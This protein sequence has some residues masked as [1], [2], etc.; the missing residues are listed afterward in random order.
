MRRIS[1]LSG[2]SWGLIAI[3]PATAADLPVKARPAPYDWNGFYFGGHVGY[4][5][6]LTDT[7]TTDPTPV[8]GHNAFGG[9]LGGGAVRV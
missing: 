8:S 1:A 9:A 5:G 3:L 7:T 6:G 2:L 4:G